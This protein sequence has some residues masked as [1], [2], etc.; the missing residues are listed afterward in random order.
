M[1]GPRSLASQRPQVD[2]KRP[3]CSWDRPD[4]EQIVGISGQSLPS[5]TRLL[6]IDVLCGDLHMVREGRSPMGYYSF[7]FTFRPR[8]TSKI[9]AGSRALSS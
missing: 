1:L 4:S 5:W 9:L 8:L 2:G 7:Y 6:K 3:I